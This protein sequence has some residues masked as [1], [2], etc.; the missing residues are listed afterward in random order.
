MMVTTIPALAPSARPCARHRAT[1]WMA[2]CAD[3]TAWHL[4]AQLARRNG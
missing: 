4:A 2:Y 3:C 1:V